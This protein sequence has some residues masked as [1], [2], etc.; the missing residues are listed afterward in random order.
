MLK[1]SVW[2]QQ[3]EAPMKRQANFEVLRVLAMAMIIAMHF[4]QKGGILQPLSEDRSAVNASAWLIEAFCIVA[5]NCYVLISGY[6]LVDTQWK[7]NKLLRLVGQVLFYSLLIPAVCYV[8]GI[9]EVRSW[10]V[11]DWITAVLPFQ[12]D[13]YWFA[14]AY[15]LLFALSP[16]LAAGV[17]QLSQKQ[18]GI[19]IAILL[20]YFCLFKSVSPILLATD[21]YGY[22]YPWFICL[23]L[24]AAYIRLYGT[25]QGGIRIGHWH[26]AGSS[27]KSSLVYVGVTLF[28]FTLSLVLGV[29]T[30][31]FGKF[32]YYMDMLFSYNHIFTLIA[33][34]ACFFAFKNWKPKENRTIRM[35]CKMVPYTF[36][37]YLL[38]EN[39][40]IRNL[41]Q[42][43]FLPESAKGS[44]LYI[45]CMVMAIICVFAAGV[46][47][48]F[49]RNIIFTQISFLGKRFY[50]A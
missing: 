23:F 50:R 6:F 14:T 10:S 48:D 19:T 36:G 35:L 29:F 21:H 3:K 9:G 44:F 8:C 39:M 16:V 40:A 17:K 46:L 41:W 34:S 32:S 15:V 47:T 38:H 31:R 13:H 24:I 45:P 18:L 26:L 11:Y 1:E 5:A 27:K 7:L 12:T 42:S 49:I 30:E 43:L 25:D 37:V 4:M 28:T 2:C 22:D 20:V 33:S